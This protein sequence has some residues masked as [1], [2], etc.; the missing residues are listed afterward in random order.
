MKTRPQAIYRRRDRCADSST[1]SLRLRGFMGCQAS[2]SFSPNISGITSTTNGKKDVAVIDSLLK[3]YPLGLIYF[4]VGGDTLE[5]LDGQQRITSIG[6]FITGKFAMPR[7][8][9]REQTFSSLPP[10]DQELLKKSKLLVYECQGFEK[11]IK[12]W[13]QDHQHLGRPLDE[14]KAGELLNS[15]YSGTFITK[16]KAE[17]AFEQRRHA[18]V[19]C[20]HQGRPEAS[21]GSRSCTRLDCILQRE[22]YSRPT[23]RSTG[24]MATLPN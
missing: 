22:G 5:V 23:W 11:E 19:G 7:V 15:I 16:A 6:R 10:E 14:K 2:S 1:T 3:R 4:N 17:T 13:F 12:D 21:R 18:E 20:Q 9:D 24:R 8:D